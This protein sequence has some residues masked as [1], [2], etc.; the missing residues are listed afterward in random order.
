M[1]VVS[2]VDKLSQES[3]ESTESTARSQALL[4]PDSRRGLGKVFHCN[5][6]TRDNQLKYGHSLEDV[7]IFCI[8]TY[9]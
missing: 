8:C 5:F 4:L 9:P 7:Y 2:D 1:L 6:L 3:S